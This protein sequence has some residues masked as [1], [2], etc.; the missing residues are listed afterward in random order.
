MPTRRPSLENVLIVRSLR[1]RRPR[2]V[3]AEVER[4]VHR[5]DGDVDLGVAADHGDADLRGADQLEVHAGVG[6]RAEELRGDAGVR[7]HAGADQR[8]LADVLVEADVGV[9]DGVLDLL[10][11]RDGGRAVALGQREGDVGEL[12]GLGRH[13]LHDHV[14]VDLG[15]GEHA[16]DLRRLTGPVR[17]AVDGDLAF[18]AVVRDARDDRLFHR[19]VLHRAGH[20]RAG[21]L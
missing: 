15:V 8:H 2:L 21:K 7:A 12:A 13:V 3:G 1:R 17:H 19:E 20:D 11:R 9:A 10:Q 5:A 14:D 6:Q 18:A 16:E 4:V